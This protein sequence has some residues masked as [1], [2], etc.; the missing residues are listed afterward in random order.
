M[1]EMVT[2]ELSEMLAQWAKE[3]AAVTHRR[4]ED[5]LIEWIERSVT[6][7]PVE[8]L[9]DEQ[10]LA[11]CE[12]Q[13]DPKQQEL[14]DDLLSRNREGHLHDAE[15]RQLDELMQIYRRGLVRKARAWKV[16][17]ERGLKAPLN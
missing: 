11:W 2:L 10:V 14:L 4:F 16:A 9:P 1:A 6:E 15:I 12:M 13:M 7:L 3:F 5:V 17:V 8:I